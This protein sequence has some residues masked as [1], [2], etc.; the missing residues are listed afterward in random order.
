M[1]RDY[2]LVIH[3]FDSSGDLIELSFREFN[4]ILEMDWLYKHQVIVDYQMKRIML[5]ALDGSEVVVLGESL[6]FLSN[7]IPTTLA[8]RL[9]RKGCEVY[10][11]YEL[12][13]KKDNPSIQEI[14]TICDFQEDFPKAFLEELQGL[15]LEKRGRVCYRGVIG[16]SPSIHSTLPH[17]PCKVKS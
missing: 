13:F 15:P 2:P 4:V 1:Y 7:V 17:D 12:E 9:I 16:Y 6:D 14:P 8:R 11:A 3:G 5:Q 10:L